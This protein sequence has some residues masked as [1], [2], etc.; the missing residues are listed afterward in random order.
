MCFS[1]FS[2]AFHSRGN[3]LKIAKHT[4]T[5]LLSTVIPPFSEHVYDWKCNPTVL[6]RS[7]A[8]QPFPPAPSRRQYTDISTRQT[9][10][11]SSVFSSLSSPGAMIELTMWCRHIPGH[12]RTAQRARQSH[13]QTRSCVCVV[14]LM[15][16][17]VNG[18]CS[19]NWRL[20]KTA[21][22]NKYSANFFGWAPSIFWVLC[23]LYTV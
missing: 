5:P 3:D 2:L 11:S 14:S 23:V 19:T 21:A 12:F 1:M 20:L 9:L 8:T 18:P 22:M 4:H 6:M 13:V 10:P 15:R 16:V 7:S 17:M